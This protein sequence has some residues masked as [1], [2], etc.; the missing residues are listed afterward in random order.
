MKRLSVFFAGALAVFAAFVAPARSY[1][2][3]STQK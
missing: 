2:E 3:K 1:G